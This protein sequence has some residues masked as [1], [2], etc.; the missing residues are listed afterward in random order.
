MCKFNNL[1][2]YGKSWSGSISPWIRFYLISCILSDN[3]VNPKTLCGI[4]CSCLV[5]L[6]KTDFAVSCFQATFG[7]C[8]YLWGSGKTTV[9]FSQLH[10]F[11]KK[12]LHPKSVQ[13]SGKVFF[14][15]RILKSCELIPI[16]YFGV[17]R[18]FLGHPLPCNIRHLY[19]NF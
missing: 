14:H 15:L 17:T 11:V 1:L 9:A 12:F 19:H 2:C 4:L 8:K 6:R 16:P 3:N 10:N 13:L 5:L 7:Y 18:C